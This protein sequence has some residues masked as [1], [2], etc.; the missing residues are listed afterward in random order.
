MLSEFELAVLKNNNIDPDEVEGVSTSY[1]VT[2]KD[3]THHQLC[4]VY[5]RVMGY[6]RPMSEYNV[7]K[8]Q[9]HADRVLF[10]NDKVQG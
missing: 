6:I 10:S 4:E 3:G 2:L 7:G 9:E 8:R 5:S 1:E